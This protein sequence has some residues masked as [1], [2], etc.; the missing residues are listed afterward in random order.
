MDK[1][2]KL[3]FEAYKQQRVINEAPPSYAPGDLAYTGDIESAPG[4]GYGIGKKAAKEGKSKTEIANDILKKIQATLFKPEPHT[5]DG[6]EYTLYYPGN[7]MKL[8]N[9]LVAIV[10]QELGTGK[11]EATYTA[12]II[13]NLSNII[14]KDGATGGTVARPEVIKRAVAAGLE[15]KEVSSTS[16]MP[17]TPAT[18]A[19][20]ETVYEIDK[21]VKLTNRVI[22]SLVNSLPDEDVP[23]REILG[24]LKTAIS[25][26][27]DQPGIDPIK[28]KSFDLLDS[29]KEAGILK[30]KQVEKQAA[31][32]EGSGEV[33]TVDEYPEADDVGSVARELGFTGRGRGG[34]AFDKTAI[35][36]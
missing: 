1:D 12:R 3:I 21:S 6:V 32:G 4:G 2:A 20:T 19:P 30:E 23:E 31:E 15:D 9:D 16:T 34:D 5:V 33:E 25:E 11:T 14:T 29:L 13:K 35:S 28:I 10:Q 27:N 8:K 18:P 7:D 26:Y 36:Y 17:A 22:K 24:I